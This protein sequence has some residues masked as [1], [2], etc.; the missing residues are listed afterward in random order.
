MP[1]MQGL[2]H[3]N[4]KMLTLAE[5]WDEFIMARSIKNPNVWHDRVPRG[6]YQL[7]NG[8]E[9]KTNIYRGGLPVQAGLS[10]WKAI[11]LSRKPGGDDVG[12]DNCAMG[13]PHTYSY[14]WETVQ[15]S[16]YQDEWQSEPVCLGDLKFVDFA[17]EQLNLIV[18]TGVDYGISMLENWNREMYVQQAMLS[19]RGMVMAT[20]ALSFEDNATY[21]FSYDPF[22]KVA[23]ADGNEVPFITFDAN[24]DIST[25]N[26]EFLDYLSVTMADRCGEA[27]LA[28]E[29]GMPVFGLMIDMLDFERMIKADPALV[30]EWLYAQPEKLIEGYS[31]G[32]KR[33]RRFALLHDSRQMRYRVKEIKADGDLVATRVLPLR[34]GRAGTIGFVPEPNPEYYRAE[35]GIGVIFM[36]DVLQNL[37]V[38]S[39]DSLGSG[40]TFGPAPGLT[41]EWRWIN[42]QDNVSNQLGETGYFYGR[43]Q[44]FPKPL[45]F[46]HDCTVFA[47]RRCAHAIRTA[48]KIESHADVDTGAIDVA[49]DAVAA[50]FDTTP[51]RITLEL[52]SLLDTRIGEAVT[53]THGGGATPMYVAEDADAP[54]YTFTWKAG[55]A[56]APSAYTDFTTSTTVNAD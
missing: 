21:R 33:Y 41:G 7:F 40:Q 3:Y 42:I 1:P 56:N 8:L 18:R 19:E 17:K 25:L 11:G 35:I 27:A 32:M 36:N 37:F 43:F 39:I 46:A 22:A 44:V 30:N 34:A 20:G 45:L 54:I 12:F 24:L 15:Y 28:V 2:I 5:H 53:V 4:D 9:Q 48:C 52:V 49:V 10:T 14:A 16:G 13:T 26:W 38:P 51:N 6:A 29:S 31:M 47:Y 50:D 55:A 23:D